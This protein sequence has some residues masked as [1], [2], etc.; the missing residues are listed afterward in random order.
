MAKRS[1]KYDYPER[2]R[3]RPKGKSHRSVFRAQATTDIFNLF[4]KPLMKQ[5]ELGVKDPLEDL[6]ARL[7]FLFCKETRHIWLFKCRRDFKII[8]PR[9]ST[10]SAPEKLRVDGDGERDVKTGD[11]LWVR[12]DATRP[13]ITEMEYKDQ[14]FSLSTLDWQVLSEYCEEVN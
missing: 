14:V 5:F 9:W 2:K 13:L 11:Y 4:L 3:G 10:T 8:G 12:F 7:E 6:Q 1:T